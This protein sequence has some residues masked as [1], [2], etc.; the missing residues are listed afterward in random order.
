MSLKIEEIRN[1]AEADLYTFIKLVAPKRV[2]GSIHKELIDW[3]Q[4]EEAKK[5]Q[6]TLLPRA[7]Q[8]SALVA[9]R[10][11]W[12]ITK[13]PHCTVLYLSATANLAEKQLKAIKDIL[14]SKKYQTYWPNMINVDAGKREK[15]TNTEISVDHPKRAEEGV[16]DPTVWAVGANGTQTGMH[17]D[18]LVCDDLVVPENAYTEEGRNNIAAKYSQ[19]ASV[20][21]PDAFFWVVG[22]RYHPKD[23]Y[24]DLITMEEQVFD[25]NGNVTD[26]SLVYEVFE[27]VVEDRG[28]GTGE[29]LWPRQQ[30]NDGVWF[31]FSPQILARIRAS[32][33]DKTQF[34]AQYY[35]DPNS[36]DDEAIRSDRFQYYDRKFI[37]HTGTH[38][39]FK[40]NIMNVYASVD[41]AYSLKQNA[42]Y[43]AVVVVGVT[44][45]NDYYVLEI[46]RFKADRP[47]EIYKVVK[48]LA[49]KWGF[50]KLRAETTAAQSMIVGQLKDFIKQDGLRV[51]IDE[52]RP[53]P[54]RTKEERI[55]AALEPLYDNLQ[56]W[57][58]KGGNCQI[59]EE[60]LVLRHPPH[61]D[62]KDALA[63]AIEIA[64]PPM[65]V[66]SMAH[67]IA[68]PL[69]NS[70]FGGIGR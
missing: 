19:M 37:E 45:N 41:F 22:T 63:A 58:Y 4:R 51:S 52:H 34:R 39:A 65:K 69:S 28:D 2:L 55:Q 43:T 5:N 32:Y 46:E 33:L 10:V 60:E 9:Y 6:L 25:K 13:N 8:K 21:N 44:R 53:P 35:N 11:A 56:M 70:R 27:R 36:S 40:N 14:I 16:R 30:R 12:W 15:W 54:T 49:F 50:K 61:D 47:S 23:I 38:W 68:K 24:N 64:K 31:G 26:T 7:H 3:W 17:C 67:K 48:S 59:L 57:H 1:L 29:F 18:V 20:A 42:D 66:L 62:V